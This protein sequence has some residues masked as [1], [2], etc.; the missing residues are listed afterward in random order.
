MKTLITS[1]RYLRLI[2]IPLFSIFFMFVYSYEELTT[3]L[4][5]AQ[6]FLKSFIFTITLWEG[7]RFIVM[8]MRR[9]YPHN[10]QTFRRFV[11]QIP[12]AVL[13]TIVSY[14]LIN[15]LLGL[16]GIVACVP[17]EELIGAVF[18]LIPTFFVMSIYESAYFFEE[19]KQNFQRSEA[20]AKENIRSQF[21]ALKSQLDPHFLFNSLNTLAALI[22]DKNEPAQAY[23]EQL[24]DVYRY[25][26]VSQQKET[27]P[28]HEEL[29][30]VDAYV[31]LNKTRFRDNLIVLNELPEAAMSRPVPPLSIQILVENAIKHNVVSR[32]KPLTLRL[33]M[34][35]HGYITVENNVQKKNVLEV[36]TKTGL[37]NMINRYALL[38]SKKVEVLQTADV[39]SVKVPPLAS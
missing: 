12:L 37:Q 34:D 36:S 26:L 10:E 8:R 9:N 35:A 13:F 15:R 11:L 28:L 21:E 24:S 16:C 19:W 5:V 18:N 6:A 30:F 20:L 39:F 17:G 1:E 2:G 32:D 27:V 14:L 3:P 4:G 38:T 23:L 29:A 25:V 31:S 7:N 33:S 22:D